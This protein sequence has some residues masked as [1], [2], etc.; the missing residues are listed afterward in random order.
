MNSEVL[1]N[2]GGRGAR[3][4]TV[5]LQGEGRGHFFPKS[6][7]R[8][9]S[10]APMHPV[11]VVRASALNH[12]SDLVGK[13]EKDISGRS[14]CPTSKLTAIFYDVHIRSW[15]VIDQTNRLFFI[16][17]EGDKPSGPFP[18]SSMY[19]GRLPIRV[20]A[21]FTMPIGEVGVATIIFSGKR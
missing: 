9:I 5:V 3:S 13:R 21:A 4:V 16:Q 2:T 10:M 1:R 11:S 17:Q 12:L 14:S 18:A 6:A 19:A 15:V 20:D 7:L 8:N